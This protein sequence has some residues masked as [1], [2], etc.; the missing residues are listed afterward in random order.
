MQCAHTMLV[1]S[2]KHTAH[3]L[4]QLPLAVPNLVVVVTVLMGLAAV[5]P[6]LPN[7]AGTVG[8]V[9]TLAVAVSAVILGEHFFL[10]IIVTVLRLAVVAHLAVV[11]VVV[12]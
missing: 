4:A 1:T 11:S 7:L 2:H 8:A 9:Q 6:R 12:A 10:A 3:V 5:V